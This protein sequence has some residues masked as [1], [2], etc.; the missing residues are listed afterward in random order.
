MSKQVSGKSQTSDPYFDLLKPSLLSSTRL[1]CFCV[2]GSRQVYRKNTLLLSINCKK[3]KLFPKGGSTDPPDQFSII[4]LS[5]CYVVF[6]SPLCLFIF[7]AF[8][9]HR[10]CYRPGLA[11]SVLFHHQATDILE[12]SLSSKHKPFYFLTF[13]AF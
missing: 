3:L 9:S 13:I 8:L 5:F 11:Y 10:N 12:N 4:F 7:L 1:V 2:F 6:S